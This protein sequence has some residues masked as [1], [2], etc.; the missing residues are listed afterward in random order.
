MPNSG[1]DEDEGLKFPILI[2][3]VG[4]TN[5]RFAIVTDTE[6]DAAEPSIVQTANFATID[7]AIRSILDRTAAKPRSAVIRKP[8]AR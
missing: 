1:D 8:S 7:D 3:D 4:G 6:S 2:G 5:A